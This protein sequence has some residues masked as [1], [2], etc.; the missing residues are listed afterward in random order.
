MLQEAQRPELDFDRL[1]E[2]ILEDVSLSY[3]L[4]R[5]VNSPLFALTSNIRS[6]RQAL[7]FFGETELRKWIVAGNAV[8]HGRRQAERTD[9]PLIGARAIL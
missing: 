1:E 2:L 6:I 8:P 4:L 5:Y 3:Q 9:P 7:L